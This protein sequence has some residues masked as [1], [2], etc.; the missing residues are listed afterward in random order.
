MIRGLCWPLFYHWPCR[1][2]QTGS[3]Q[4]EALYLCL[5]LNS[6]LC[7]PPPRPL[8]F[9]FVVFAL[10]YLFPFLLCSCSFFLVSPLPLWF[11]GSQSR[12][13]AMNQ[14]AIRLTNPA[15]A[16]KIWLSHPRNRDLRRS[17]V[18]ALVSSDAARKAGDNLRGN[19]S[20]ASNIKC[21]SGVFLR[22]GV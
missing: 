4:M 19:Q 6:H 11:V 1:K 15:A 2:A 18:S 9:T 3:G 22:L 12:T 14:T 13:Q 10:L 8:L 17:A 5:E 16:A 20:C 21:V 7:T